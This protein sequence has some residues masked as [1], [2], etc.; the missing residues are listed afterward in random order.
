MGEML[1]SGIETRVTLRE[2][3]ILTQSYRH[4]QRMWRNFLPIDFYI[5]AVWILKMSYVA[6]G[7]F[8]M[9]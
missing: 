7:K 1:S 5:Y 9:A 2:S 3:D 8:P 4:F 6:I